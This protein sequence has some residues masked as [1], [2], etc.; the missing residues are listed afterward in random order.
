MSP[1]AHALAMPSSA[2]AWPKTYRASSS[3]DS[4]AGDSDGEVAF[5]PD[6]HAIGNGGDVEDLLEDDFTSRQGLAPF[7]T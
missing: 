2:P 6:A 4:R 3:P 5:H 1:T 7:V